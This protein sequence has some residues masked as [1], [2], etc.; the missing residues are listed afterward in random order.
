MPERNGPT[1]NGRRGAG[2][3]TAARDAVTRD[4]SR[5]VMKGAPKKSSCPYNRFKSVGTPAK[6]E[7]NAIKVFL[8]FIVY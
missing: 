6:A 8:L 7:W 3:T 5:P 4:L 2:R 1:R